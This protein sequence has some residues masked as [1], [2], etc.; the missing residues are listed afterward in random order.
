MTLRTASAAIA[1]TAALAVGLAGTGDAQAQ[2]VQRCRPSNSTHTVVVR[3]PGVRVAHQTCVIRFGP[4]GPVKAWVHTLWRRTSFRTVF[5]QYTV[6]ARLELRDVN[7]LTLR[8]RYARDINTSTVGQRTCET[9]PRGTLARGWTGD[10]RVTYRA[11][12]GRR[13]RGLRGSPPV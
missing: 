9:T 7:G 3:L 1:L 4:G 11:G 12:D 6:Q 8:C 2:N 13:V 10:G 5:R